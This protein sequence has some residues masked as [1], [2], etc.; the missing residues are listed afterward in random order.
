VCSSDLQEVNL[1]HLNN[2]ENILTSRT[3]GE[4]L[5]YPKDRV[6]RKLTPVDPRDIEPEIFKIF[7]HY[8]DKINHYYQNVEGWF[9]DEEA[10]LY[11][12]IVS[13]T[14]S[15]AH[16]VEIGSFKG[17]SASCMAVEI[18]NSK[19][20]I[21]FDC[22]DIWDPNPLYEDLSYEAFLA[23][24]DPMTGYFNALRMTS[25]EAC[26]RYQDQSLDFVFIDA[27]HDY[28]S[29]KKDIAL[30]YPKVKVGGYIAGHDFATHETVY[31]AV[32]DSLP[33]NELLAIGNCFFM[34]KKS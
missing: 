13:Q 32:V 15:P 29:V 27:L 12:M 3:N 9:S 5:Y 25:E 11:K 7:R 23:N 18:F 26:A 2:L 34:K 6:V 17:R 24:L 22:V 8:G 16:F 33:W 14:E 28:D 21:Q 20:N 31:R 10:N 4:M 30:W 19:K 1:P